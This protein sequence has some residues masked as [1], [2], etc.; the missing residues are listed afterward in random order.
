M[1]AGTDNP[2]LF[3]IAPIS[4]NNAK[5]RIIIPE[6][7]DITEPDSTGNTTKSIPKTSDIIA[8]T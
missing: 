7:T 8:E 6:K 4:I 1:I 2:I 5:I 3:A